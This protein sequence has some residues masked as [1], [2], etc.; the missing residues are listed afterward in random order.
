MKRISC[1]KRGYLCCVFPLFSLDSW[2]AGTALASTLVSA[3]VLCMWFIRQIARWRWLQIISVHCAPLLVCVIMSEPKYF[4]CC[5]SFEF[6]SYDEV[7]SHHYHRYMYYHLEQCYIIFDVPN[8]CWGCQKHFGTSLEYSNH[9]R[10]R[11]VY[12][13]CNIL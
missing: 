1:L 3:N 6:D 8:Y 13:N 10:T 4:C 7:T 11:F 12:N 9:F 5:C 2:T